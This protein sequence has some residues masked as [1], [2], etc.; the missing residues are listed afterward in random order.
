MRDG[1]M[2]LLGT[3]GATLLLFAPMILVFVLVL[4][5]LRQVDRRARSGGARPPRSGQ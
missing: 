1:L 5:S 3:I 2:I 4:P